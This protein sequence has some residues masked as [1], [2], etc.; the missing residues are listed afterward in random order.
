MAQ[1]APRSTGTR[2][3]PVTFP[4]APTTP[5]LVKHDN[6]AEFGADLDKVIWQS[7][8]DAQLW[9]LTSPAARGYLF[10]RP[11][12]D[13]Q[14]TIERAIKGEPGL[15]APLRILLEMVLK[16]ADANP[17]SV[18][19][20]CEA[21]R[22][23]AESQH[24]HEVAVQYAEAA[25]YALPDSARLAA[26]AGQCCV[27]ITLFGRGAQ[28]FE[29]SVRVAKRA[30]DWEWCIRA[31]A[32]Y[33]N[34]MY[35]LGSYKRASKILQDAFKIARYTK[36]RSLAGMCRHYQLAV[37]IEVSSFEDAS[38]L[39]QA[40]LTFYRLTWSRVAHLAHDYAVLLVRHRYFDGAISLLEATERFFVTPDLQILHCGTLAAAY[41]GSGR[42]EEYD[43]LA[44]KVL[45]LSKIVE[46]NAAGGLLGLA[47]GA[48]LLGRHESAFTLATEAKEIAVRRGEGCTRRIAEQLLRD[49]D[50]ELRYEVSGVGRSATPEIEFML[51]QFSKRLAHLRVPVLPGAPGDTPSALILTSEPEV[52]GQR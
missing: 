41:A 36:K 11:A 9:G 13:V 50:L 37:A 33:G 31:L 25:A 17:T 7:A 8:R 2:R 29:R 4:A 34:L 46:T 42:E 6:L 49:L 27:R 5:L 14:R 21:M 28:W 47:D 26:D 32:R 52:V 44:T 45:L 20:A 12:L 39:A 40:A 19:G 38:K 15:D 24:L 18:A 51:W 43:G 23:W 16:P 3:R 30:E 48:R 35:E 10:K 1:S 22:V